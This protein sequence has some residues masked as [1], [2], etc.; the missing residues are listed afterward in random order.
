[1]K[2]YNGGDPVGKGTYWNQRIGS[3]V[4][5]KDEA[6]LPGGRDAT[7][8]R[9]PFALLFFMVLFLGGFYV[10]LLP[11]LMIGMGFY[12]MGRRIFGGVLFQARKN[13]MFGWRPMEAYLA[14]KSKKKE[15][16]ES[17]ET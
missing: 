10:I 1:M 17:T 12:M 6:V 16:G 14:G 2:R 11:L 3:L 8:Y 7:F 4:Q 15:N 5:V 13:V 9:I